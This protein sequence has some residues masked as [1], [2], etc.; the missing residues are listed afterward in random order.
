MAWIYLFAAGI[1]EVVW[2]FAMKK[3]D[4]FTIFAPTVITIITMKLASS[5]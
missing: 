4:G 1:L 5:S 2:A 3:S